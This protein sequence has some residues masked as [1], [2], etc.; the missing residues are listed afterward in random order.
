MIKS[1]CFS[2]KSHDKI[3]IELYERKKSNT[4][5]DATFKEDNVQSNDENLDSLVQTIINWN[6]NEN[7]KEI[8]E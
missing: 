6:K 4:P 1:S 7:E 8:E 2:G 5:K 3:T